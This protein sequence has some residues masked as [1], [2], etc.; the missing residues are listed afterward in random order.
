[1]F[2]MQAVNPPRRTDA[3]VSRCAISKIVGGNEA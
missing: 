2:V 3:K 1:M